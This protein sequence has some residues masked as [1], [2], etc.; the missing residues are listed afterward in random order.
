MVACQQPPRIAMTIAGVRADR[1]HDRPRELIGQL[2]LAAIGP[3]AVRDRSLDIAADGLA[4][5]PRQQLHGSDTLAPQPSRRTSRTSNT[6]TSR[7]AIAAFL[8]HWQ[9]AASPP[10]ATLQLVN[11]GWSHDWRQGGPMP[12]AELSSGRPIP[13]VGGKDPV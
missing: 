3:Q 9:K 11:P 5:H 1:L 10:A 13:L 2:H 8:S 12:L 4:V 6:G 7:N